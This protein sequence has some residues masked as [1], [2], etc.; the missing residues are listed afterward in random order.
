MRFGL[1]IAASLLL[2][3]C[4]S[5]TRGTGFLATRQPSAQNPDPADAADFREGQDSTIVSAPAPAGPE[6]A[7]QRIT[8]DG[9]TAE[10]PQAQSP[11]VIE[12]RVDP[13]SSDLGRFVLIG[14]ALTG[15]RIRVDMVAR[16]VA[17]ASSGPPGRLDVMIDRIRRSFAGER[18]IPDS[19]AP[20]L[21]LPT[22]EACDPSVVV[23]QLSP[24]F[25]APGSTPPP[26]PP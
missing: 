11:W 19:L 9:V 26:P 22:S 21:P 15:D 1:F 14:N 12:V 16:T 24:A 6:G 8:I 2:V 17:E 18:M 13:C 7:W 3:A 20:F 25:E 4:G 23:P 5:P 10:I